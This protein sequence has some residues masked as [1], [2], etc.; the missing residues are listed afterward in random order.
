MDIVTI[1]A[2]L[3]H[4]A[5]QLNRKQQIA[6]QIALLQAEDAAIGADIAS[7]APNVAG[8]ADALAAL[9]AQLGG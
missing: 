7:W 4:G 8:V 2:L 9:V 1:Q 6:E 5:D 3:A